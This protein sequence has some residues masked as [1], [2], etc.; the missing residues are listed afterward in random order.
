MAELASMINLGKEMTRK[1]NSVGIGCA[2]E[3][4]AV[5]SKEAFARLKAIYPNVC[6]VHLYCLEG[7]IQQ[8]EYNSLSSET[9]KEL[10]RFSDSL[11][12]Q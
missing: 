1:L 7:A 11:K 5:G 10:K 4:M 9:R 6:L 2:E 3:L 8:V 12:W